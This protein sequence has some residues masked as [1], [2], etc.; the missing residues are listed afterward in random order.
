VAWTGRSFGNAARERAFPPSPA[1]RLAIVI[2]PRMAN[3]DTSA[4]ARRVQR[5]AQARLGPSALVELA[6]E[7][8]EQAREIAITGMRS[9]TPGLSRAEARVRL[10]RRVLG[11]DLYRAAYGRASS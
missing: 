5:D 1:H 9:R 7:M 8:S 3:S 11:E 10:L 4:E 6:F 2:F